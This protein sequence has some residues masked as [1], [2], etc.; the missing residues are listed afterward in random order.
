MVR[1]AVTVPSV[2][3]G[4]PQLISFILMIF[5]S[6]FLAAATSARYLH[7]AGKLSLGTPL[8]TVQ[9]NVLTGYVDYRIVL[10]G[11]LLED[12]RRVRG[13]DSFRSEEAS[14][15]QPFI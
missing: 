13:G 4:G 8:Q 9:N 2:T 3:P 15:L 10:L 11:H 5:T 7:Q 1:N 14:L 12:N 6:I